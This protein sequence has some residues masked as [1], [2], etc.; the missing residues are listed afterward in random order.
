MVISKNQTINQIMEKDSLLESIF[1][2]LEEEN[3][4][5]IEQLEKRESIKIGKRERNKVIASGY[6]RRFNRLEKQKE[7]GRQYKNFV[8]KKYQ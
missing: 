8:R 6:W 4:K 7:K 3:I 5:H 2:E 1:R